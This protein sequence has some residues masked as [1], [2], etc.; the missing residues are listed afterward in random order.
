MLADI[1]AAIASGEI[2]MRA[3]SEILADL[4]ATLSDAATPADVALIKRVPTPGDVREGV[5][6]E[7]EATNAYLRK[8]LEAK[9]LRLKELRKTLRLIGEAKH[10]LSQPSP[11]PAGP[12]ASLGDRLRFTSAAEQN[13]EDDPNRKAWADLEDFDDD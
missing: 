1:T 11:T 12:F 7:A 8:C 9:E 10:W 6:Y 2:S 13:G 4:A 5:T 3:L